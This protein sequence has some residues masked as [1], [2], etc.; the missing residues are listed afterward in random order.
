V[1]GTRSTIRVRLG[2]R[3][4]VAIPVVALPPNAA[5]DEHE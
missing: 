4:I 2:E 3:V 1:F 5:V